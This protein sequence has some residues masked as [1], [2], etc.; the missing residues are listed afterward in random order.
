MR[1][2]MKF[3]KTFPPSWDADENVPEE[4]WDKLFEDSDSNDDFG[5]F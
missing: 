1:K 3:G 2:V 4:V 5:G